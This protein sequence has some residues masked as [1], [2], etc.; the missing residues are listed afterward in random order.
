MAD[1]ITSKPLG[2]SKAD[3]AR[4]PAQLPL[5]VRMLCLTPKNFDNSFSNKAPCSPCCQLRVLMLLSMDL[6]R[7]FLSS[8]PQTAPPYFIILSILCFLVAILLYLPNFLQN[9]K[10]I[11]NPSFLTYRHL[12][13]NVYHVRFEYGEN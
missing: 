10:A 4:S 8:F 5:E 9:L 12:T 7:A 6:I 2:S 13:H 3:K 11:S 1:I